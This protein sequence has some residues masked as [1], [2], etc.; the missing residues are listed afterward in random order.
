M[1]LICSFLD[2]LQV[3]HIY[4]VYNIKVIYVISE[5]FKP[6][7]TKGIYKHIKI[8][9]HEFKDPELE[10]D[11]LISL[12]Y[13]LMLWCISHGHLPSANKN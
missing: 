6:I 10:G 3:N 8:K 1:I 7:N 12:V 11:E 13:D 4:V 9:R 2:S 5:L